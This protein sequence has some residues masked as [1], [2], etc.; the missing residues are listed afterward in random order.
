MAARIR[1]GTSHEGWVESV[2]EKIR[3][4][5]L[6]NRLIDHALGK[7][8]MT[9]TQVRSAEIC[10][11]KT[12]PNLSA[13]ENT[14]KTEVSFVVRVPEKAASV[15]EWQNRVLSGSLSPAPKLN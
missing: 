8:D 14:N 15:E 2:R 6:V 12:I 11:N 5:M 7:V 4:S 1:R 3:S 10:L 9:P 13:S